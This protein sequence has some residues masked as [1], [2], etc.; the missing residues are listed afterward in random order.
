MTTDWT[1]D[2][3]VTPQVGQVMEELGPDFIHWYPIGLFLDVNP[4]QL[5]AIKRNQCDLTTKTS[6]MV[7][8]WLTKTRSPVWRD[9][10]N[11][12]KEAGHPR[13]ARRVFF[14][15]VRRLDDLTNIYEAL[16]GEEGDDQPLIANYNPGPQ[17][18]EME[19]DINAEYGWIHEV[20]E[21]AKQSIAFKFA[22]MFVTVTEQLDKVTTTDALKVFLDNLH[23]PVTGEPYVSRDVY[24]DC[25]TTRAVMSSL[26]PHHINPMDMDLLRNIVA[27][28]PNEKLKEELGKYD[29]KVPKFLPT[30]EQ[31]EEELADC[32]P[33]KRVKVDT[34]GDE[35]C[36]SEQEI[37]EVQ[38]V[39]PKSTGTD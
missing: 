9:L 23:H 4:R 20:S 16:N 8:C 36:S 31:V 26:H 18:E 28:F 35:G 1:M 29:K 25:E 27:G 38:N 11:A 14:H 24:K 34:E 21:R 19:Y 15:Y 10:Y 33:A 32:P 22:F 5:D 13:M 12:L 39:L 2:V 37:T 17:A 6:L 3:D 30:K 7:K